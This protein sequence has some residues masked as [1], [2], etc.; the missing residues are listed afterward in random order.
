MRGK[1]TLLVLII[2]LNL[3]AKNNPILNFKYF[4]KKSGLISAYI[5]D[6]EEDAKGFIWISSKG[7]LNRVIGEKIVSYYYNLNDS[8]TI[9][10]SNILSLYN[11][12]RNKLWV[13]GYEGIS[14]YN[15]KLDNFTRISSPKYPN[16]L[17]EFNVVK[18]IESL[19]SKLYIAS[20]KRVY[21]FNR[22]KRQFVEVAHVPNGNI[23]DFIITN[24][25]QLWIGTDDYPGLY[26]YN[27]NSAEQRLDNHEILHQNFKFIT[28]ITLKNDIIYWG[29]RQNGVYSY[30]LKNKEVKHFINDVPDSNNI[31]FIDTDN[32]N[33]IWTCDY[34][35]I[36]LFEETKGTF[37]GYYPDNSITSIKENAKGIFQD[38]QGNYWV[39]HHPGGVGLS[40]KQK[41]FQNINNIPDEPMYTS[42]RDCA[43]FIKDEDGNLWIGSFGGTI[44]IFDKNQ[45]LIDRF[46]AG[47][48]G[49]AK[50][51]ILHLGKS[52]NKK[53]LVAIY[54]AGLFEYDKEKGIF[55]NYN[56]VSQK[57]FSNQ[58]IRSSAIDDDK[59]WF[60]THGKGLDCLKN[61]KITNYN[62]L[63]SNLTN[64]W[65]NHIL[66]RNNG[67]LWVAT[68]WGLNIL[69]KGEIDFHRIYSSIEFNNGLTDNHIVYLFEDRRNNIWVGTERGLCR[70]N[71]DTQYFT[72]FLSNENICAI[73]DD[74][75]G[76]M[77]ITTTSNLVQL[78]PL[79]N[80]TLVFENLDGIKVSEFIP[81]SV[82]SD[83]ENNKIY[84]G[85]VD[86]G[87]IFNPDNLYRNIT[88]PETEFTSLKLFN[89]EV[90]YY[91]YPEIISESIHSAKEIT[92]RY[93]QNVITLGFESNNFINQDKNLFS[94]KL[95]GFDK[96]WIKNVAKKEV[97]YTNIAPGKYIFKVKSC[98]N[99]GVWN[100]TPKQL[101]INIIPPWYKR[102]I[103]HYSV[104]I[105]LIV[106]I[107]I[108]VKIRT[109]HLEIQ[110]HILQRQVEE[111]TKEL[112]ESNNELQTQAEYL[113]ELNQKLEER[114]TKIESQ[115]TIL[116]TQSHNLSK[117]NKELKVLNETKDRLFSIISHDLISPFNSILGL[118]E[119]LKDAST[120]MNPKEQNLLAHKINSS[121]QRVFNLLQNLLIWSKTQSNSVIFNPKP[122]IL[123]RIIS[124]AIALLKEII[125][126]K[127]ITYNIDVKNSLLVKADA[128]ML[129]TIF[130]NIISNAIKFSPIG[131]TI[132]ISATENNDVVQIAI[133]D[134]GMGIP[135]E[136]AKGIFYEGKNITR[137][138]TSGEKGS[139]LGLQICKEFVHKNGGQIWTE[140]EENKGTTFYFTL[141]SVH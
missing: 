113:L 115:S 9:P 100:N 43:N 33:Q 104:V 14:I 89:K 63:N 62:S 24:D 121:A 46:K 75:F 11:D 103:T 41:G 93:Y 94:Y 138:G 7:G 102:P 128:D 126:D 48:R 37:W 56:P 137:E 22:E 139:G 38:S 88:P 125:L 53:I 96:E 86:G 67:D 92:L 4:D 8:T 120:E 122:V 68:S 112:V 34:T 129:A 131:G 17:K 108:L 55:E 65:T 133:K 77:W 124:D 76:N 50:G 1:L 127:N 31:V 39:L 58:D 35:G 25:Q 101:S 71:D 134:N 132:N 27:L 74:H 16:G 116:K 26:I 28:S 91:D 45:N 119:L 12:S 2:G 72:S 47:D 42:S 111:K 85:G 90:N 15:E 59:F 80:S 69:K 99:D 78:D 141:P 51:S 135:D 18:F 95:E 114:Q 136:I 30:N 49:L 54:N 83:K 140:S 107:F 105:I 6:I 98:N 84:F 21:I 79:T 130:R 70:Y 5:N 20:S 82:F 23:Q 64:D 3:F 110:Q 19:D 66:L 36:K 118:T 106:L 60:A 40:I 52:Q 10:G 109:R 32:T 87:I 44:D 81:K 57:Y 117:A 61:G 13:S 29:T 123:Y 73:A 97:T